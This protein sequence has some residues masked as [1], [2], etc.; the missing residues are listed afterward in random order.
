M[1]G[2]Q[3]LPRIKGQSDIVYIGST[4]RGKRG[5]RQRLQQ[6]LRVREGGV[7]TG[8]RLDRVV[9][10]VGALEI[11]WLTCPTH[12][13]ALWHEGELLSQYQSDHIELPPLNRQESGKKIQYVL[14]TLLKL[15]PDQA[16]R[17]FEQLKSS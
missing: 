15:P 1:I 4:K 11:A 8:Y 7:D 12:D 6:H 3:P 9:K 10:E 2:G 5:I 16:R 17:L 13:D 14:R